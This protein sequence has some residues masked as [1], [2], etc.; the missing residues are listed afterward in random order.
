ML[1]KVLT[2]SFLI[3]VSV[4][5]LIYTFNLPGFAKA[6]VQ[7][8]QIE[9]LLKQMEDSQWNI[10]KN[11]FY[12]LL[13]S[14]FGS[15]FRGR[16]AQIPDALS[17][18]LRKHPANADKINL[19]LIRL[20]ETENNLVQEQNGKFELTGQ[21]LTEDYTNYHGDLIATVA[22]LKDARAVTA[23]MGA[24]NTGN[25]AINGLADLAPFSIDIVAEKANSDH[26][27]TK[28][29]ATITLSKMLEPANINR[30]ESY[31]PG[32]REKIK[33]LLLRKAQDADFNV[34]LSAIGGLAKL[35]DADA[36]KVLQ[37]VSQ[38]DSY[39]IVKGGTTSYP[40]REAAKNHLNR[41]Q[42]NR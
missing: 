30:L 1:N 27:L 38:N 34:R 21:V 18:L 14:G 7:D 40:V 25:L 36:I 2:A 8:D 35:Q 6:N 31:I 37:E 10:R 12:K 29:S 32:S 22:G 17:N 19:T 42:T 3:A 28:N 24:I 5:G 33:N 9:N 41:I 16:T 39:Q 13:E 23:L 20:L 4:T 26:M 11:A 15:E